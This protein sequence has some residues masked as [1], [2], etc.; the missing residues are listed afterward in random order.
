MTTTGVLLLLVVALASPSSSKI[1]CSTL[2]PACTACSVAKTAGKRR[3]CNSCS[4]PAYV[5]SGDHTTCGE[6]LLVCLKLRPHGCFFPHTL[7]TPAFTAD[8]VCEL[9]AVKQKETKAGQCRPVSNHKVLCAWLVVGSPS[10]TSWH[11]HVATHTVVP[12]PVQT[13]PLGT[14]V[15]LWLL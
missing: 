14:V 12:S 3:I 4:G 15:V 13:V 5:L 7:S 6:R 1:P 2:H 11:V 8:S 9:S 10:T